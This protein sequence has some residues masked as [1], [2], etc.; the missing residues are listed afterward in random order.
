VPLA[1]KPCAPR[2]WQK[3]PPLR[4]PN[5]LC[6]HMVE[7]TSKRTTQRTV[8]LASAF[9]VQ[10]TGN[11]IPPGE[12]ELQTTEAI[13]EGN[14][15]SAYTRVS[16]VLIVPTAGGRRYCEVDPADLEESLR[17]NAPTSDH[18]PPDEIHGSSARTKKSGA[19]LMS[20]L[21]A[22][23]EADAAELMARHGITKVPAH[24]YHYK[25]WRY[26]SLADALAQAKRDV[27]S[28]N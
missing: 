26:S 10:Q 13:H 23:D 25:E 1:L 8:N 9:H 7:P 21:T 24:Q 18:I 16:T 12:Y 22:Q 6:L 19:S 4:R 20:S 3:R 5:A 27:A 15:R 17:H 28:S 2:G 14:D 11:L